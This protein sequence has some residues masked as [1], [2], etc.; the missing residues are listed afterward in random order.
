MAYY[1]QVEQTKGGAMITI[2]ICNQKGGVGKS[3]TAAAVAA[4][5]HNK[6]KRVLMVDAD[7]QSNLSF[8]NGVDLLNLSRSLYDVFL[9][10]SNGEDLNI[11]ET[12]QHVDVAGLDIIP[13]NLKLTAADRLFAD[14]SLVY[15]LSEVLEPVQGDYDFCVVDTGPNLG[16]LAEN[17]MTAADYIIIPLTA[18]MLALQGMMQL[19]GSIKKQKKHFN[20]KL[21][22]AGIL[23]TMYDPRK[24]LSKGLEG[25]I[26]KTADMM[27]TKV[28]NTRIRRTQAISNAIAFQEDIYTQ[29]PRAKATADYKTFVDELLETIGE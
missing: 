24:A 14:P 18:D 27:G 1:K 13:G 5:L 8:M 17:A 25:M 11:Q 22:I 3:T 20:H 2:V 29:A 10:H 6:G 12:I 7:P 15:M 4:G 28:F 9:A 16:V 23:L 19:S 26:Q 21:E